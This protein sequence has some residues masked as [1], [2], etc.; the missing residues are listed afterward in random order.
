MKNLVAALK[1]KYSFSKEDFT[2][3]LISPSPQYNSFK[4]EFQHRL[5]EEE[6]QYRLTTV[7]PLSFVI[8]LT[9]IG[10]PQPKPSITFIC[11]RYVRI[12]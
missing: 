5:Q 10:V 9:I 12:I 11:R 1:E 8:L 2:N 3:A 7:S 6:E 4:A